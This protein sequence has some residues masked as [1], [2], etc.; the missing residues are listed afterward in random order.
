MMIGIA[1]WTE[2]FQFLHRVPV[3]IKA[4]VTQQLR[5]IRANLLFTSKN[6]G[7]N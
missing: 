3:L 2:Y 4:E 1:M 7:I 5:F 6:Q